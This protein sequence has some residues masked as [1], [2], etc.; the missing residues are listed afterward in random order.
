MDEIGIHHKYEEMN[1][2]GSGAYGTVYKGRNKST[3]TFVALK[4]VRITLKEEGI[5]SNTMREIALLKHLSNYG[6]PNVIQ[7]LDICHGRRIDRE[8]NMYIVF[9]H[10]EEDLASYL[11]KFKETGLDKN[12]KREIS[13]DIL[14]GVDFLHSQRIVHRDLKP[15]NLLVTKTGTIKLADFGLAKTYDCDMILT[16][17]VVTLWYRAPEVLLGLKYATPVD[18]WSVGCIIAELYIL[19]PLFCGSAEV[20]Q[21]KE[22][23]K[24]LGTPERDDWPEEKVS[25]QFSSFGNNKTINLREVVSSLCEEGF[26]LITKM[27]AFNPLKRITASDALHHPYFLNQ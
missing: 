26:D 17:V 2:I 21:L 12:R 3:N 25:F 13:R 20:Q 27:L 7:I 24:V 4:R 23:F 15:Q 6:H 10:M 9:E 16:A 11:E 22:I 8:L 14:N 19:K 1:V 5:P 18:I